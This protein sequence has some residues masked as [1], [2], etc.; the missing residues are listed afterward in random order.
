MRTID[1]PVYSYEI[2]GFIKNEV[3]NITE[4]FSDQLYKTIVDLREE[5]IREALI[6]AGWTPPSN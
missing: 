3:L 2:S 1:K 6:K 4:K 5:F